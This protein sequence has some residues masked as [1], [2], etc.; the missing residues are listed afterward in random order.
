MRG[1]NRLCFCYL[2]R[3]FVPLYAHVRQRV[4]FCTPVFGHVSGFPIVAFRDPQEGLGPPT[5]SIS[6]ISSTSESMY[7]IGRTLSYSEWLE[8]MG[9]VVAF[10]S[11]GSYHQRMD[12]IPDESAELQEG[13]EPSHTLDHSHQKTNI[14]L[15]RTTTL[16]Q[17]LTSQR[18]PQYDYQAFRCEKLYRIC[19]YLDKSSTQSSG[20]QLSIHDYQVQDSGISTHDGPDPSLP[21][22]A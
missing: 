12:V 2:V 1:N 7:C 20:L 4:M 14:I 18:V 22:Y 21:N 3:V 8:Q 16:E 11:N 13:P 5:S 10:A 6:V 9:T 19:V 17:L 15:R